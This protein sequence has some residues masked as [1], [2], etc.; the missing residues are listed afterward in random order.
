MGDIYINDNF[1]L[2]HTAHTSISKIN[3]P[4][5]AAGYSIKKELDF[6]AK[7]LEH[8]VKPYLGNFQ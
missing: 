7:L 5:R 3:L 2:A 8:P 4:I 6:F 1:H